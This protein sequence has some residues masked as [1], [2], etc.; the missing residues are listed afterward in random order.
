[1]SEHKLKEAAANAES[2]LQH[3]FLVTGEIVFTISAD[4]VPNAGR[5]NAVVTSNDGRMGV[6]HLAR[7]QMA[8]QGSF[9]QKIQGLGD[10]KIV[11]VVIVAI[12]P[13]GK[14]TAEEFNKLP[15]GTKLAPQS[16]PVSATALK[17]EKMYGDGD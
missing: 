1:M 6:Q 17:P 12:M 13:L 11:D 5:V 10:V 2:A 16:Q 9:H 14:W 3:Y 4:A 7:A 15:E 8:L